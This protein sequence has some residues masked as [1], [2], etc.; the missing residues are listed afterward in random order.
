M[1]N[2]LKRITAL[3]LVFALAIVF[4]P[5]GGPGAAYAGEGEIDASMNG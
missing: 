4:I 2:S 5:A 1:K 3:L